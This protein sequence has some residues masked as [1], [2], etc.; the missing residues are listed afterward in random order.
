M[1]GEDGPVLTVLNISETLVPGAFYDVSWQWDLPQ[2]GSLKMLPVKEGKILFI[3]DEANLI[4]EFDETNN[5]RS[6]TLWSH[7]MVPRTK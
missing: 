7:P 5:I 3:A 4:D 2:A 6:V 1:S